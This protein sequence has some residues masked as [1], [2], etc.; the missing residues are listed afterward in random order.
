MD[1]LLSSSYNEFDLT[2][3]DEYGDGIIVREDNKE[4]RDIYTLRYKHIRLFDSNKKATNIRRFLELNNLSNLQKH[5]SFIK[6]VYNDD[7][8]SRDFTYHY[9]PKA[10]IKDFNRQALIDYSLLTITL[11]GEIIYNDTDYLFSG[12]RYRKGEIFFSDNLYF[13]TDN[14]IKVI[15]HII[16]LIDEDIT[17]TCESSQIARIT[18]PIFQGRKFKNV[19]LGNINLDRSAFESFTADKVT[20]IGL[21]NPYVS[22][23]KCKELYIDSHSMSFSPFPF[24]LESLTVKNGAG[25]CTIADL[26]Y[27]RYLSAQDMNEVTL[28]GLP[29]LKMLG[30][31][32]TRLYSE[33]SILDNLTGLESN[34]YSTFLINLLEA[35]PNVIS[36]KTREFSGRLARYMDNITTLEVHDMR[37]NPTMIPR[38]VKTLIITNPIYDRTDIPSFLEENPNIRQITYNRSIV[39]FDDF[40]RRFPNVEILHKRGRNSELDEKIESHN[41]RVRR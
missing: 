21:A 29:S 22:Y 2:F 33:E 26:P 14:N 23:C 13:R 24:E 11:D 8:R 19:T 16:S 32:E 25:I 20:L 15:A 4:D 27:L 10:K 30:I 18:G 5:I 39:D 17:L 36:Y 1:L 28:Y 31:N 34:K 37:N 40:D 6:A 38:N 12:K 35:C 41:E 3:M 7:T 9:N